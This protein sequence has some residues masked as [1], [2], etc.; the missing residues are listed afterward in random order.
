MVRARREAYGDSNIQV[1]NVI[2]GLDLATVGTG[3]LF[4]RCTK[5]I[6]GLV[7]AGPDAR[8][9]GGGQAVR[10]VRMFCSFLLDSC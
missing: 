5:G 7:V 4:E 1:V 10:L 6:E 9:D 8:V 3:G 2:S